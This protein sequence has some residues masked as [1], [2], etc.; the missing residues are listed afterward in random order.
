MVGKRL[1]APGNC[2]IAVY[3]NRPSADR[4]FEDQRTAC[5]M[6]RTRKP[7]KGAIGWLLLSVDCADHPFVDKQ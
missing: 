5:K 3:C 7:T 2:L 1:Q 4:V 6:S